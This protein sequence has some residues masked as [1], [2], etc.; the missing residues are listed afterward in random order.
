MPQPRR[1]DLCPCG[2]GK[3]YKH[4]H[5]LI[6]RA[7]QSETLVARQ[8]FEDLMDALFS[9][10]Q[11]PSYG[12][13]VDSAFALFWD[14]DYGGGAAA[15]L[16]PRDLFRFFEWF[17]FD[18]PTHREKRRAVQLFLEEQGPE[19]GEAKRTML[20][21]WIG[22]PL[23]LHRVEDVVA[24]RSMRLHDLL[25]EGVERVQDEG[26][27]QSMAIGDLVLGRVLRA[28][29]GARLSATPIA[30]PS[31]LQS[32]MVE[33]MERIWEH[34][35]EANP[36]AERATFLRDSSYMLNH[37]LL[38]QPR[39]DAKGPRPSSKF[40]D[41]SQAQHR[42]ERALRDEEESIAAQRRQLE[43]ELMA[44]ESPPEFETIA[45]GRLVLPSER[46]APDPDTNEKTFAGGKLL[47]P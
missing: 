10:L 12:L 24:G 1:N 40:Y 19:L 34:Y 27:S 16:D 31:S 3:K 33:S 46:R 36:E 7:Q 47:L 6:D 41:A 38:R 39:G 26:L 20:R 5:M 8:E 29:N 45:G 21:K 37:I 4:C 42:L 14:G 25:H 28:Q 35:R 18:Y 2:S 23:S 44:E 15:A 9:F 30:L 43:D 13:D 17:S 22:A 11:H 32:E